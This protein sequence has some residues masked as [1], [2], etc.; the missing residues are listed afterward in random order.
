M[1]VGW[2][3]VQCFVVGVCRHRTMVLYHSFVCGSGSRKV[4][5]C[6]V[7][8]GLLSADACPDIVVWDRY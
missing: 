1:S 2:H 5:A 7:V 8:G 6:L 4:H 3:R